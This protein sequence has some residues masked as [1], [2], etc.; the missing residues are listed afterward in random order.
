MS[1]KLIISL[2]LPKKDGIKNRNVE[3]LN[4]M[5]KDKFGDAS[6]I[7]LYDNNS[8]LSFRGQPAN[9]V[10]V[11]DDKDFDILANLSDEIA[12]YQD[13]G[14][15]MISEDFNARTGSLE[16]FIS[17]NDDDYND[18]VPVPE[19]YESDK[20]KQS[21]M[22]NDNKSCSR[23][24]KNIQTQSQSEVEAALHS[25]HDILKMAANKSFKRKTKSRRNGIRSKPWFDKGLSSMRK[26]LD[27]KNQMLTRYPKDPIIRG[28]FF[29]F[30]KL[31][32]K[33]CKLQYRQYKLDIIQ[34]LD[35]LFETNPSKYWELLNKLKYEDENKLSRN[36]IIS[37]DEWFKHFQVKY[38]LFK[39]SIKSTRI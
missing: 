38:G 21:R 33:K 8:N 5:I 10:L 31:Y 11:N 35:N 36:S 15:V 17:N 19:E 27:H 12:T 9:G 32:G 7:F 3:K 29:K 26:E 30:R 24:F 20:T 23:D 16:D 6:D 39:I 34:K 28:H 18:Y 13:K 25:L 22:S 4:I 37:A 1:K 2:G 14:Q